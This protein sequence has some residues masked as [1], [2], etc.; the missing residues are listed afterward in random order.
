MRVGIE[1]VIAVCVLFGQ[2]WEVRAAS[3]GITAHDLKL[4]QGTDRLWRH[5]EGW[6]V[7][8]AAPGEVQQGTFALPQNLESGRYRLFVKARNGGAGLRIDCGGGTAG[9]LDLQDRD[10]NGLWSE[11]IPL[12]IKDPAGTVTFVLTNKSPAEAVNFIIQ[13]LY[14]TDRQDVIVDDANCVIKPAGTVPPTDDSPAVHGNLIPNGSFEVGLGQGWLFSTPH[15]QRDYS[16]AALWDESGGYHGRASVRMPAGSS[17]TSRVF[18]V[19][20]WRK[21]SF[22]V[23]VHADAPGTRLALEVVN[24]HQD[25][26]SLGPVTRLSKTF[27]LENRWQRLVLGDQLSGFPSAEYQLRLRC[28]DQPV[29]IDA[30]QLE[31]GDASDYA[32]PACVEIGLVGDKPANVFFEDEPIRMRLLAFNGA[33][34]PVSAKVRYEVYDYLNRKVKDGGVEVE[35]PADDRWQGSLDL[36]CG[37][38]GV[39]RLVIWVEGSNGSDEEV[40]YA[41]VARPQREGPDPS[42]LIGIH[43]QASDF[44]HDVLNRLGVKW[45][46]IMSPDHWFRWHVIEPERGTFVWHDA[47]AEKTVRHGLQIL[48][49]IGTNGWPNWAY[50]DGERDLQAW[51]ESVGKI[52]DHYKPWVK[53]WEIWNEPI[54]HFKADFYAQLLKSAARAIRRADPQAKIVGMGGSYDCDWCLDVI[55]HLDNRPQ[56]FMDY[57]S[58]HVYCEKADPLNPLQEAAEQDFASKILVPYSLEVWNTETGAWCMGLYQGANSSFR[59]AGE[60][61]WPEREAWRY[62]RGFDYEAARVARNFLHSIG[63]GFAR[64]FYYD[65]RFHAGS[66]S[67]GST[68]CTL[69]D[70]GDTIRSKGIAYATLARYFDHSRG[71]GNVSPNRHAFAYLFDRGGTALG[72]VFASDDENITHRRTIVLALAPGRVKAYDMMGNE[73]EMNGSEVAFG[74]QPVYLEG[75]RGLS[76]GELRSAIENSVIREIADDAAPRIAITDAPRG[77]T[78]ATPVRI[79]WIAID[80]TAIPFDAS[81]GNAI[82]YS[83]RLVGHDAEWSPWTA[84]TREDYEGL[85]PGDYRFE[86]RAKDAS[87]NV[88]ESVVREFA[89]QCR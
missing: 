60:P 47:A 52:V 16:I 75:E 26:G 56:D 64:Y 30:L 78:F 86:V 65:C 40:V 12:E 28:T 77:T 72:A 55:Q 20:P 14:F 13:A 74:R 35:A 11:A 80:E 17:L 27:S 18:R 71:L 85:S 61:I 84:R 8:M 37:K 70:L 51:E 54:H 59:A 5:R 33:A 36:A 50:K 44:Q 53:T 57:L 68:H 62:Y 73:V 3:I 9:E 58:T 32:A 41:V 39:F 89:M 45:T 24:V 2:A 29:R 43:A 19:R 15:E 38:R 87:G 7:R 69:F 79:R 76:V 81:T 10:L 6:L 25:Y 49:M 23:W 21:H 66:Y 48:G 22:S 83:Y 34:R 31:E 88:S 46:R 4:V 63:N 82:Q 1:F 42:S 67:A